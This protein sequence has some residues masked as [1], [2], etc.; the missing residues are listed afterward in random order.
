MGEGGKRIIETESERHPKSRK[1]AHIVARRA[2]G[3]GWV[4]HLRLGRG[5]FGCA[6]TMPSANSKRPKKAEKKSYR[7]ASEAGLIEP[8]AETAGDD[9]YDYDEEWANGSQPSSPTVSAV[10]VTSPPRGVAAKSGSISVEKNDLLKR[11]EESDAQEADVRPWHLRLWNTIVESTGAL[12]GICTTAAF[13]PQVYEIWVTGDTSGLSLSMYTI[14]V[15]GVLLWMVYGVCK[16]A[17]SLVLA[18]FITFVLAGYIFF[19]ILDRVVLHPENYAA[20]VELDPSYDDE[21][22]MRV[23]ANVSATMRNNSSLRQP[24]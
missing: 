11:G 6:S 1:D 8:A 5:T 22:L 23:P 7:R 19:H 10:D 20:G 15:F 18:N 12:A 4:P 14:F 21:D 24:A 13:I 3:A 9:D 17:G 2:V 16:K